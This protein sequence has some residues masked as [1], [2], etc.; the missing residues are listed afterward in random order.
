MR[1]LSTFKIIAVL[2]A[3]LSVAL[4][5]NTN[6]SEPVTPQTT[7]PSKQ[8]PKNIPNLPTGSRGQLLYENHCT[9]CHESRV[10][11]RE[12]RK[13]RSVTDIAK[14]VLRWSQH[15]NLDW[16]RSEINDV[17]E[18]LNQHFYQ[19]PDVNIEPR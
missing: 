8:V 9:D 11:I 1:R 16:N 2:V 13:S 19:L 12:K 17:T 3:C 5:A 4:F 18:Y 6:N 15:L 14:W 10:Y 7:T